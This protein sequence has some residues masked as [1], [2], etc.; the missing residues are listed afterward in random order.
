M[1]TMAVPPKR[2][3]LPIKQ[4]TTTRF[5]AFTQEGIGWLPCSEKGIPIGQTCTG[6]VD[7]KGTEHE[8]KCAG[9]PGEVKFLP[10]K[11]EENSQSKKTSRF[12][13]SAK[14]HGFGQVAK[15]LAR[16]VSLHCMGAR[17]VQSN[18]HP[19]RRNSITFWID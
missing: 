16:I 14:T 3:Q 4:Q 15:I 11:K 9:E 12:F 18:F 19:A 10:L 8:K 1:A 13:Q 5:M 2:A 6:I 7:G 17:N